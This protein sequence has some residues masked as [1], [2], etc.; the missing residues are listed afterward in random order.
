MK[1]NIQINLCGRLYQ[2]DEDAYEL[3]SHYTETLRNYFMKQEGGSEIADDIEQRIAELF[4]ELMGNGTQAITIENVQSIIN[5][6][7]DLKDITEGDAQTSEKSSANNEQ[8]QK[9]AHLHEMLNKKKYY[10][11]TYHSVLFGVLSGA[12]HYIGTSANT[13][14]WLFALLC[15][16]WF[17]FSTLFSILFG[18]P[19]FVLFIPLAFVP[20]VIYFVLGL[21]I[22]AATTPED[23][24]R[25][26]G[27]PVTPQNLTSEVKKQNVAYTK[28]S[29]VSGWNIFTGIMSI[30]IAICSAINCIGCIIATGVLLTVFCQE[31]PETLNGDVSPVWVAD[32]TAFFAY[33]IIACVTMLI[34]IGIVLYCSIHSSLSSFKKAK[35]MSNLQRVLWAIGWVVTI[36]LSIVF[37]ILSVST[38]DRLQHMR[39]EHYYAEREAERQQYIREDGFYHN[40]TDWN[41]LQDGRWTVVV[42]EGW[43]DGQ[44]CTY[45]GEYMDGNV[46]KRY[47]DVY[48]DD[49]PAKVLIQRYDSLQPGTYRLSA[50][51]KANDEHKCVFAIL[52]S[53]NKIRLAEIPV[54]EA[55][56]GP[57]HHVASVMLQ[58]SFDIEVSNPD[59]VL[60]FEM[61][62]SKTQTT[63]QK[64]ADANWGNGY[65]WSYVV[66]DDLV[67]KQPC[68]ITYG[69]TTLEEYT[70]M[71]PTAGWFS[72][73]DFKIEKMDGKEEKIKVKNIVKDEKVDGKVEQ[74]K[75]KDV[76]KDEKVDDKVKST[77]GKVKKKAA[78]RHK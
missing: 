43:G 6:I 49:T 34:S 8:K 10:R 47:L 39:N 58:D 38:Y 68:S 65:G 17:T 5:Q 41:F 71:E 9:A 26:R 75:V 2:I 23:S 33:L 19:I 4:D 48:C 77:S 72:A 50:V 74:T 7:G 57:I 60:A 52:G 54:Y 20:E 56:G 30:I 40:N 21:C 61:L 42:D 31:I 36:T 51:V 22:P 53:D 32:R 14:R 73:T 46:D 67:V 15:I 27:V 66:I 16:G 25:M 3:L 78:R 55:E 29:N 44:R 13:L 45:S 37:I 1:K 11:D 76:V 63:L 24:L 64:I 18:G 59:E 62:K 28:K 35:P 70:G 69:V 12:A